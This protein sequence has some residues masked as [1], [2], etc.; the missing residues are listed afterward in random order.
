MESTASKARLCRRAAHA[1][2]S[3]TAVFTH[4]DADAVGSAEVKAEPRCDSDKVGLKGAFR[5]RSMC[6]GEA[7][8]LGHT[9]AI[10]QQVNARS[11]TA[12][13]RRAKLVQLA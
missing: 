2:S 10:V 5:E 12:L 4:A 6:I 13:R 8:N 3:D 9:N 7:V 11:S 1:R